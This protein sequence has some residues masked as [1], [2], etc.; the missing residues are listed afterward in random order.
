MTWGKTRTRRFMHEKNVLCPVGVMI[1]GLKLL[2]KRSKQWLVLCYLSLPWMRLSPSR[3]PKKASAAIIAPHPH[4]PISHLPLIYLI[5]SSIKAILDLQGRYPTRFHTS[6]QCEK[7]EETDATAKYNV[8][9]PSEPSELLFGRIVS[10][11]DHQWWEEAG[12]PT[13]PH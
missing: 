8:G 3:H 12:P 5:P 2:H 4:P 1:F 10:V 7:Y 9:M 13:I 6:L 11:N